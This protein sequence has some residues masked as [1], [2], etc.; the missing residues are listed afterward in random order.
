VCERMPPIDLTVSN[1][2]QVNSAA[3]N[4]Y[5]KPVE[6]PKPNFTTSAY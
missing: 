3:N 1:S 4:N 2:P 6:L 5:Y